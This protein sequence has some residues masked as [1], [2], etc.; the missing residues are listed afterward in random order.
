MNAKRIVLEKKQDMVSMEEL[1]RT[2]GVSLGVRREWFQ[3][4]QS[5]TG[6]VLIDRVLSYRGIFSYIGKKIWATE[7]F[8][9]KYIGEKKSVSHWTI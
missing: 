7:F 8:I 2:I 9:I 5:S 6:K 1:D 3:Y 4:I